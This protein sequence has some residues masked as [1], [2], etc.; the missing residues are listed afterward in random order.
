MRNLPPA[1]WRA[2]LLRQTGVR[3]GPRAEISGDVCFVGYTS[4]IGADAFIGRFCYFEDQSPVT[5]G[6][7]VWVGPHTRFLTVTHDI[8]GPH[9]R[10][11]TW[12]TAP[13]TVGAGTWIGGSVTVLPG[14]EIGAGC[15]V[16]AGSVVTRALAPNGLYAGVPAARK[17]D[18]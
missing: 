5:I 11:G 17:R 4:S 12:R 13:I 9:L 1:A 2:R 18:L 10:A 3:V 6:D 7:N 15:V 16:A 8:G 14:V